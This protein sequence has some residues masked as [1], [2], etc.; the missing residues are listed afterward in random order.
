MTLKEK[1]RTLLV[2]QGWGARRRLAKHLGVEQNYI[3]RYV[4]DDYSI[5]LPS[6]SC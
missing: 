4:E 1:L 5:N 3:T 6:E 2:K